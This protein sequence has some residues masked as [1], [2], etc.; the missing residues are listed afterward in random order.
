MAGTFSVTRDPG[1][2]LAIDTP[3]LGND[4]RVRGGAISFATAGYYDGDFQV[5]VEFEG[6]NA[7]GVDEITHRTTVTGGREWTR[8]HIDRGSSEQMLFIDDTASSVGSTYEGPRG[9]V[10]WIVAPRRGVPPF[11]SVSSLALEATIEI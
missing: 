2:E 4:A 3:R 6:P 10:E 8:M 11:M 1:A 7:L 5:C 9:G